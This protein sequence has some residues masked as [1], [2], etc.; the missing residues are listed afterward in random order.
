MPAK[1]RFQCALFSADEHGERDRHRLGVAA[2]EEDERDEELVP[3]E[4]PMSTATVAVTGRS[5]GNTTR[6][7]VRRI[8]APSTC[9]ASS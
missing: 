7:Y 2:A 1:T 8:P 4:I 3:D 9:A 6:T 5:S